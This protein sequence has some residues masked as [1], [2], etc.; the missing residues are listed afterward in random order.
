MTVAAVIE[1]T[2]SKTTFVTCEFGRWG[3]MHLDEDLPEA[4]ELEDLLALL[5]AAMPEPS[6]ATLELARDAE[7]FMPGRWAAVGRD[8]WVRQTGPLVLL[9]APEGLVLE[10]FSGQRHV[11][12]ST[13]VRLLD[14][15]TDSAVAI[16]SIIDAISAGNGITESELLERVGRLCQIA[17]VGV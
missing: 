16:G 5:G 10:S 7:A 2:R 6:T 1:R 13:D 14:P 15:L 4:V 9:L 11:L 17:R 3:V 8:A 12:D